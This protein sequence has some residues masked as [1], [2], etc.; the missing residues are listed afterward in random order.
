MHLSYSLNLNLVQ[1]N[2]WQHRTKSY[3]KCPLD[4]QGLATLKIVSGG[5]SYNSYE[6]CYRYKKVPGYAFYVKPPYDFNSVVAHSQW[7]C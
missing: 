6:H 1:D 3:I 5:S 7:T 2:R 4:Q